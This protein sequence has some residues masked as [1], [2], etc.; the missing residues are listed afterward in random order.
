MSFIRLCYDGSSLLS[1]SAYQRELLRT[2]FYYLKRLCPKYIHNVFS[3]FFS[4]AFEDARLKKIYYRFARIGLYLDE[5]PHVK[6][7]AIPAVTP[8]SVKVIRKALSSFGHVS[9]GSKLLNLIIIFKYSYRK[10]ILIVS[11][12]NSSKTSAL[13]HRF[14]FSKKFSLTNTEL[15]NYRQYRNRLR[16]AVTRSCFRKYAFPAYTR[17]KSSTKCSRL[18]ND[19]SGA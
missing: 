15:I 6:L 9:R 7:L 17:N 14:T 1:Y 13:D 10:I 11:E 12:N 3:C 19:S 18:H 16:C 8:F 2:V 4:D 5:I